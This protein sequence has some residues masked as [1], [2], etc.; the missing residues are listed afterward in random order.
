MLQTQTRQASVIKTRQHAP[1]ASAH[2]IYLTNREDQ[3]LNWG[4]RGKSSWDIAQI[5]GCTEAT[6]NFHFS[7]IRRKFNVYSRGAAVCEALKL[8]LIK[9]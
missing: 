8:G 9:L 1:D 3:V 7:N 6:V 2:P 4:A 5:L